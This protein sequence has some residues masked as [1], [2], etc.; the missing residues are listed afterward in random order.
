MTVSTKS[1]FVTLVPPFTVRRW[2]GLI[3]N[4]DPSLNGKEAVY[5]PCQYI[6]AS[7][8]R[9]ASET[10]F[11]WPFAGGPTVARKCMLS[12]FVLILNLIL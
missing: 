3:P 9:F 7:H 5:V 12:G 4:D 1:R 6:I 11:E 8:Y 10:P 2:S